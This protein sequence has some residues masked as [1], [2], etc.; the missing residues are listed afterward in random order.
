[1]A[2]G[3]PAIS[4]DCRFEAEHI[5]HH[6]GAQVA[7]RPDTTVREVRLVALRLDPGHK[8]LRSLAGNRLTADQDIGAFVDEADRLKCGFR[9]VPQVGEQAGRRE[10]RDV[11]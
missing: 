2:G 8:I 6:H 1:M 11:T 5:A 3:R 9:I 10:Q 7:V 4:R